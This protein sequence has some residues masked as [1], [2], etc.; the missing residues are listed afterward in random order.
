MQLPSSSWH[1]SVEGVQ[2]LVRVLVSCMSGRQAGV[3]L[4]EMHVGVSHLISLLR[5]ILFKS[6]LFILECFKGGVALVE[7]QILSVDIEFLL[8]VIELLAQTDLLLTTV[9]IVALAL[10]QCVGV[11]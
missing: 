4:V 6:L 11:S 1:V 7:V 9:E 8:L 3:L 10:L 2:V 5:F